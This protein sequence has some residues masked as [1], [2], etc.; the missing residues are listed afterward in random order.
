[1]GDGDGDGDGSSTF[2]ILASFDFDD[3]GMSAGCVGQDPLAETAL[4]HL[5][6]AGTTL[7]VPRLADANTA[8]AAIAVDPAGNNQIA[9]GADA[10]M[11]VQASALRELPLT[12]NDILLMQLEVCI[13]RNGEFC[14]LCG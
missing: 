11:R 8:L 5:R 6:A 14:T 12:T 2:S 1:M 9:V 4:T 7:L 3:V 10:N 13:Q